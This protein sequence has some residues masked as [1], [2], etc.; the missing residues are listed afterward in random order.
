MRRLVLRLAGAAATIVV[1]AVVL[2][3][4]R[5]AAAESSP[6]DPCLVVPCVSIDD[7]HCFEADRCL[8]TVHVS[9]PV[10][11]P[12]TVEVRTVDG[13]ATAPEDYEPFEGILTIE[14]GSTTASAA[15]TIVADRLPEPDE[16]FTVV[17]VRA[18]V[19][20]ITVERAT[21]T[22]VETRAAG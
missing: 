22:I 17:I 9:V 5:P 4:P 2:A 12:V 18:S 11:E 21:I 16:E 14:A 13:T 3:I 6:V 10:R 7:I 20:M 8:S 15:I 1:A 19:E